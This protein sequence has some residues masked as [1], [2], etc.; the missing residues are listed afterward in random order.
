LHPSVQAGLAD[1][2]IDAVKVRGIQ[3]IV[4]SHS[5]HL[6]RWLPRRIAEEEAA[7]E[8]VAL[9]FCE[10][11]AGASQISGLNSN[12]F[13][14]ITNWP[15]DFFVDEFGEMAA[16]ARAAMLRK[17][18]AQG[19]E[20]SSRAPT[21]ASSQTAGRIMPIRTACSLV[22]MRWRKRVRTWR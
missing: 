11:K 4:E 5:E 20:P 15:Q 9:Y 2:F 22:S 17:K 18:R 3:V 6:L 13:G 21:S 8:D 14:E 16:M 7:S 10:T 1:V 19:R 12:L